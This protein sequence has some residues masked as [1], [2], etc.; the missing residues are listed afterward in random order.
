MTHAEIADTLGSSSAR[1]SR[2][3]GTRRRRPC[4]HDADDRAV[5]PR[6]SE[7]GRPS[8][9]AWTGSR[10]QALDG[11]WTPR[12]GC[13]H[14]T[15]SSRRV[16]KD[17]GHAPGAAT[18]MGRR[19]TAVAGLV[20]LARSSSRP[21]SCSAGRR[22]SPSPARAARAPSSPLDAPSASAGWPSPRSCG[23]RGLDGTATT[24]WWAAPTGIRRVDVSR[25]SAGRRA[26]HRG[27]RA[28]VAGPSGLW[29]T[30]IGGLC[31]STPRTGRARGARDGRHRHR[32]REPRTVGGDRER[33]VKVEPRTGRIP[34]ARARRRAAGDRRG[35]RRVWVTANDGTLRSFGAQ[36]CR[37]IR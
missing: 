20:G 30:T 25:G 16:R 21:W 10:P 37:R 14:P 3:C 9:D 22:C 7:R 6:R 2:G 8:A 18:T 27:H 19:G 5:G 4:G 15:A 28:P 17:H 24:L 36:S 26:A 11:C 23:R 34:P 1:S 32:L 13:G 33:I 31:R 35:R 29:A 12:R